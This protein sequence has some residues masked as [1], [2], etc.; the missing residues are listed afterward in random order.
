MFVLS[1]LNPLP[2]FL[3]LSFLYL[4]PSLP[5]GGSLRTWLTVNR[6][7]WRPSFSCNLCV[8]FEG[9][10]AHFMLSDCA[11]GTVE[12]AEQPNYLAEGLVSIFDAG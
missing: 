12:Q 10:H 4:T 9:Q 3:V 6:F 8:L 5:V 1:G 7:D 11:F 2:Y